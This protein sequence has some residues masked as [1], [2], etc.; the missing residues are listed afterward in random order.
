[1]S[2][3]HACGVPGFEPRDDSNDTV[4]T[5]ERGCHDSG[6]KPRPAKV[7]LESHLCLS[8]AT[9]GLWAGHASTAEEGSL[10]SGW[11]RTHVCPIGVSEGKCSC[12]KNR[13]ASVLPNWCKM[14]VSCAKGP[15]GLEYGNFQLLQGRWCE[16]GLRGHFGHVRSS[17]ASGVLQRWATPCVPAGTRRCVCVP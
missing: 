4:S 13:L 10:V 8:A 14:W 3:K 16:D 17:G 2:P 7:K 9:L 6:L 5:H 11:G 12:P 1:M 15:V